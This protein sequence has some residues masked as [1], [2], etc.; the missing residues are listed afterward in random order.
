MLFL[1]DYD[2]RV[3]PHLIIGYKAGD[4]C[5]VDEELAALLVPKGVA[6][7]VDILED[8][9]IDGRWS[10]SDMGDDY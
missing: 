4:Q 8:D 3:D 7:F 2:H 6:Q 5:E 9:L 1:S 10:E